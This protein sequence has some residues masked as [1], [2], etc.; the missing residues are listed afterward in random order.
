MKRAGRRKPSMSKKTQPN[1]A[2]TRRRKPASAWGVW[3]SSGAVVRRVSISAGLT[4]PGQEV[5]CLRHRRV[6]P[7]R[8]V[9]ISPGVSACWM[10]S[11]AR[12]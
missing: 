4:R 11:C 7:G 8:A 5:E 6:V 12:L 10:S 9:Y 2:H 3:A 1:G